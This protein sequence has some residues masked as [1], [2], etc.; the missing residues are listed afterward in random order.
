MH[1]SVPN[2]IGVED[3]WHRLY[4]VYL[5][6]LML[7]R[8]H[9]AIVAACQEIRI[10]AETSGRPQQGA[11]TF[12][13]EIDALCD[14]GRFDDAWSVL[15]Q[16][17]RAE[18]GRL[19]DLATHPWEASHA[20]VLMQD[21]AP[22]LYFLGRVE[23]GCRLLETA[24][25]FWMEPPCTSYDALFRVYKPVALPQTKWDVTLR[26][27]YEKL[28]KDLRDWPRWESFV[29]GFDARLFILTKIER[30]DLRSDPSLLEPFF[31]GLMKE[32]DRRIWAGMSRGEE[33]LTEDPSHVEEYQR[34][35][36]SQRRE[37]DAAIQPEME[38]IEQL[39]RKYFPQLDE[40]ERDNEATG[41]P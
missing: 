4:Q 36:E 25:D 28:G 21:Y 32:R 23:L 38:R 31:K 37:F 19:L 7:L 8:K 2:L 24:L 33:D 16:A 18:W 20:D 34:Q 39:M 15:R 6:R 14:L 13:I 29:T 1:S 11:L 10:H 40:W 27:F 5:S 30:D 3:D 26:H 12:F 22:I 9:E 41:Q 35:V 17:E